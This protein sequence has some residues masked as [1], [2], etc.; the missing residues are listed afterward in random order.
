MTLWQRNQDAGWWITKSCAKDK[1][2]YYSWDDYD[3]YK[4]CMDGLFVEWM[5]ELR[6]M[7][8]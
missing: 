4:W 8:L 6:S 2:I 7:N 3:Y 5:E 1:P